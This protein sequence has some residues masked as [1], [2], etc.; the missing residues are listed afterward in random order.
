[1]LYDVDIFICC[2]VLILLFFM[3][4]V[5][6]VYFVIEEFIKYFV[7]VDFDI[8]E[9]LVFKMVILVECYSVND[10]MWFIEIVM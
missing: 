1:M 4:D 2:C 5:F 9:E 8:C 10:C 3:C 6:N 7:I